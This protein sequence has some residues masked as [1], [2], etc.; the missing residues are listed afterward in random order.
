MFLFLGCLVA[1]AVALFF[2]NQVLSP[3]AYMDS[4]A[5]QKVQP[6]MSK[7]DVLAL[8]GEPRWRA[9]RVPGEEKLYYRRQQLDSGPVEIHLKDQG[10]GY[11]A[12]YATCN[13]LG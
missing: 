2:P 9:S 4:R 10:A 13:G 12:V 1:L 5:C 11:I 3:L 6:G 7:A 8:M